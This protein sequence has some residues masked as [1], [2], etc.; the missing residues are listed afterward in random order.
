M[1][2]APVPE[3]IAHDFGPTTSHKALMKYRKLRIAWSVLCGL[4]CI[5][6]VVLWVRSY[7]TAEIISHRNSR[8]ILTVGS[9]HGIV[10][11]VLA[12]SPLELKVQGRYWFWSQPT[13]SAKTPQPTWGYAKIGVVEPSTTLDLKFLNEFAMGTVPDYLLV[14]LCVAAGAVPWIWP[15]RFTLRTLLIATTLVAIVLGA[16]A[17]SLP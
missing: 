11:F 12:Y 14:G 17:L 5:L 13:V 3:R 16:I 1:Q 6:L 10:Y 2:S 8:S 7:W 9:N 15:R 4:G